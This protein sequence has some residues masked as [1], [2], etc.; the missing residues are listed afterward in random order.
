M[1]KKLRVFLFLFIL[2]IVAAVKTKHYPTTTVATKHRPT[3][4]KMGSNTNVTSTG[5]ENWKYGQYSHI[6][7]YCTPQKFAIKLC[8]EKFCAEIQDEMNVWAEKNGSVE[9]KFNDL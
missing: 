7:E 2:E 6:G 9:E 8:L 1:K 4:K 5:S 3:T